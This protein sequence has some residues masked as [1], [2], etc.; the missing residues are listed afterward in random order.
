VYYRY[1]AYRPF[2]G[3][4]GFVGVLFAA[5][6]L[7]HALIAAAITLGTILGVVGGAALAIPASRA[8]L[9][10]LAQQAKPHVI[11]QVIRTTTLMRR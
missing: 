1:W 3:L 5:L 7:V 2:F 4:F 9:L 10:R 11:A 6:M 8:L